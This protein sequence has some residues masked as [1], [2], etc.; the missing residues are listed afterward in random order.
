M[1]RVALLTF[2]PVLAMVVAACNDDGRV[3]RDAKPDQTQS[4]STTVAPDTV[5]VD[6]G[7]SD[8]LSSPSSTLPLG[9]EEYTVTAPWDAGTAID[10]RYTCNGDNIAPALSWSVA[11]EGTVEIAISLRDID[12]PGFTHWVIAGISPEQIALAED[13]VPVG[14]YQAVNGA[15]AVGYTGP[16]PPAGS[17]HTYVLTVHYLGSQTNLTD[18]AAA[19]ELLDGISVAEIAS[20]E[21]DGTFSRA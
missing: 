7:S 15:G 19:E 5:V 6:D 9:D 2:V 21:V 18:G 16:C 17:A 3:L 11:P 13:T 20:A 1:R 4:I 8:S 14:A 12:A 10:P